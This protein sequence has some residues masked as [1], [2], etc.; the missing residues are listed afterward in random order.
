MTCHRCHGLMVERPCWERDWRHVSR[1]WAHTT[2][3]WTC[4][5]CGECIDQAI[6]ANRL[7]KPELMQSKRH[8]QWWKKIRVAVAQGAA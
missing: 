7:M 4:V 3:L 8:A 5:N 1:R 2:Y 6:L